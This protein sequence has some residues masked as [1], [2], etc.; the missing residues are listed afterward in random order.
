[1][2]EFESSLLASLQHNL[3]VYLKVSLLNISSIFSSEATTLAFAYTIVRM[4]NIMEATFLSNSQQLVSYVN[5]VHEK[6]I[7]R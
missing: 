4:L 1:M 5:Y 3:N 7:P 2:Q 6:F